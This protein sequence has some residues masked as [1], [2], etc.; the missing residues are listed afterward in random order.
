M[1]FPWWPRVKI[2][3]IHYSSVLCCDVWDLCP[4]CP[5]QAHCSAVALSFCCEL[6]S[7]VSGRCQDTLLTRILPFF[8]VLFLIH[9]G[10]G[11]QITQLV[12]IDPD[13]R[14]NAP[15]SICVPKWVSLGIYPMSEVFWV[16]VHGWPGLFFFASEHENRSSWLESGWQHPANSQ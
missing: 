16:L 14:L 5:G 6:A 10:P 8:N 2:R 9:C 7:S 11:I 4:K 13:G 15:A 3:P 1:S 12:R